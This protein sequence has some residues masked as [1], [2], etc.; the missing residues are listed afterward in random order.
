MKTKILY[1]DGS[2]KLPPK[3]TSN[4]IEKIFETR[5]MTLKTSKYFIFNGYGITF[6]SYILILKDLIIKLQLVLLV[7]LDVA[8]IYRVDILHLDS[9]ASLSVFA[10][11]KIVTTLK[12]VMVHVS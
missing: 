6:N 11:K 4:V 8:A 10:V 2:P 7:T 12:V 3:S 9:I 5:I 1:S